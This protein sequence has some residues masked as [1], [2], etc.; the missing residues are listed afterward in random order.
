[1]MYLSRW[2]FLHHVVWPVYRCFYKVLLEPLNVKSVINFRSDSFV[3]IIHTQLDLS[4]YSKLNL[5]DS[6]VAVPPTS[7]FTTWFKM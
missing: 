3:L 6:Y 2:S 5:K 1:M 7:T 4:F